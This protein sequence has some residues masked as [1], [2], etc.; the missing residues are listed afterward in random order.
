MPYNLLMA[1]RESTAQSVADRWGGLAADVSP[2][3]HL[4]LAVV[5]QESA[6]DQFAAR[7]E[8]RINDQSRG[9]AQVLTGTLAQMQAEGRVPREW[10][11]DDL[12]NPQINL[13]VADAVL[14]RQIAWWS[15]DLPRA[16]ASYNA[17]INIRQGDPLTREFPGYS[18]AVL[19][20]YRWFLDHWRSPG[21]PAGPLESP[22]PS[23]VPGELPGDTDGS[24]TTA[25]L[26]GAGGLALGLLVGVAIWARSR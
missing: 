6:G 1:F 23:E 20:Y 21:P 25:F 19:A 15:G 17:G 3:P 10:G 5:A 16:V 8:P 26:G 2:N 4:L 7:A 12:W 24:P 9:L 11:P 22:P 14:R 13:Q 18:T